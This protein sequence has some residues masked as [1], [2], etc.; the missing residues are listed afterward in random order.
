MTV[1]VVSV[2]RR[3]TSEAKLMVMPGGRY[4]PPHEEVDIHLKRPYFDVQDRHVLNPI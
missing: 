4:L 1:G 3:V 2:Y